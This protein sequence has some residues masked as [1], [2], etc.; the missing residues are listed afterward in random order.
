MVDSGDTQETQKQVFALAA[1]LDEDH[2]SRVHQVWNLLEVECGLKAVHFPPYPHFSFHV[3][4]SYN[5][6]ELDSCLSDLTRNIDPFSIRTNGLSLFTGQNPVVYIPVVTSKSLL[7]L[8][9]LLWEKTTSYG[10]QLNTYYQPGQWVPH[11]T[12]VHDAINADRLNCI[13][14]QFIEKSFVWEIEINKLV[15]IYHKDGKP[16][17]HKVYPLQ[18]T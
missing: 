15:I 11:I 2:T 12:L 5:L 13:F 8:H 17:I 3:A 16:G 7:G 4:H 18:S 9:H 6:S 10:T 1:L 14:N